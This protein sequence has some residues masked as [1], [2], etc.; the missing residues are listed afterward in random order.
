MGAFVLAGHE[1]DVA[2]AVEVA[3]IEI[4]HRVLSHEQAASE[5]RLG[6]EGGLEEPEMG[7]GLLARPA[8]LRD[9]DIHEAVAIEV[10]N[11]DTVGGVDGAADIASLPV[12]G[13]CTP[14]PARINR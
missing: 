2:V 13:P 3:G 4:V 14:G 6:A 11:D 9:R 5:G 7:V 1:I 10:G 8:F 12:G